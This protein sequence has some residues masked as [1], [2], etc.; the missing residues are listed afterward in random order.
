[1]RPFLFCA[2]C[3]LIGN[4]TLSAVNASLEVE[5]VEVCHRSG[6]LNCPPLPR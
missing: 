4:V 1:M 2:L 6:S 5:A 3:L